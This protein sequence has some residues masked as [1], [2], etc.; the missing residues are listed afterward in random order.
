[1]DSHQRL[2]EALPARVAPTR[3]QRVGEKATRAAAAALPLANPVR[4]AREVEQILD[5]MLATRWPAGERIAALEHLR[6]PIAALDAA[7]E[8]L[9][10]GESQPLPEAA[11][12]A[13]TASQRLEAK[14]AAGY[15]LGLHEL[16]APEGKLPRFKSRPAALA[17]VRALV[18]AN[19]ALLWACR[20]YQSPPAGTWRRLHAVHAFAC[21][22]GLADQ[23]IE[24][25]VA[26][27]VPLSPRTAYAHVLLLAMANPYRFSARELQDAWQVCRGLAG[28]CG[29]ARAR[30]EGVGVDTA[31]DVGPGAIPVERLGLSPGVISVDTGPVE[32]AL[33]AQLAALPRGATSLDLGL[34]GGGHVGVDVAFLER[35]RVGWGLAVRGYARLPAEHRLEVVVGMHALHYVL[36]GDTDFPAF[37]RQ[38]HNDALALGRHN[39]S[40]AWSVPADPVRPQVL[41]GEVLDQSSGGYRLRL[42]A[43]AGLRVRIGDVI[44]LAPVVDDAEARDWM[45]GLVRWLRRTDAGDAVSLGVELLRRQARAAGVLGV[46][47]SG[48]K[49]APMR[50]VELPGSADPPCLS[51]L[52]ARPLGR[53]VNAVEVALPALASDWTSQAVVATWQPRD[54]EALGPACFRVTLAREAAAGGAPGRESA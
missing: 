50:A 20:Q 36:A 43:G 37:V 10:A 44:G 1:M 8:R 46:T 25:G 30:A 24:D 16:C 33:D 53:A 14:L 9:V 7:A 21:E 29:F 45:V 27:G 38:V 17:A 28:L 6:A 23:T 18:H 51:L 2:I 52:L 31:S 35:L 12:A 15:A 5:D 42:P 26:D 54:S 40:P 48:E 39:P 49:L 19:L 13:A 4:A 47:A 3:A 34:P 41:R 32:H 11:A 22:L